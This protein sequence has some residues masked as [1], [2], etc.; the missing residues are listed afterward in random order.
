[1]LVRF[2]AH[3]E[4]LTRHCL[5]TLPPRVDHLLV[6]DENRTVIDSRIGNGSRA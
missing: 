4:R 3:F 6:L 2:V 5:E 1:M